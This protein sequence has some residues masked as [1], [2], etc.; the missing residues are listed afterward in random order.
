MFLSSSKNKR[1]ISPEDLTFTYRGDNNFE[2]PLILV[3][4]VKILETHKIWFFNSKKKK[5]I[6]EKKKKVSLVEKL[7]KQILLQLV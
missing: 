1:F 3:K 6:K 5:I 2:R 7:T 4:I